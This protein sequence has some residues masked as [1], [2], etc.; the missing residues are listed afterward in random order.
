MFETYLQEKSLARTAV[1]LNQRGIRQKEWTTKGGKRRGGGKFRSTSLHFH[2]HNPLFIGKVRHYEDLYDGEHE[3]IV[4]ERLFERVQ[5][6]LAR[7][8]ECKKSVS[9]NKHNFLLRGLVR[10]ECCGSVMTTYYAVSKGKAHAYYRCTSVN[11]LNRGQCRVRHVRAREI[12]AFVVECLEELGRNEE[13]TGRV[14]RKAMVE[15][16]A[17]VPPLRAEQAR[18][19]GEMKKVTEEAD[20]LLQVVTQQGRDAAQNSFV[21]DH[22][23]ELD[24]RKR[25]LEAEQ[26]RI[27]AELSRL[28]ASAIDA[29]ELRVTLSVMKRV[30]DALIPQEQQEL[31]RLLLKEVVYDGIGRKVRLAVRHLPDMGTLLNENWRQLN[32]EGSNCRQCMTPLRGQ[33]SNLSFCRTR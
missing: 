19:A 16:A 2:L 23:N 31:M 5:H 11:N 24:G 9:Q 14:V 3:G 21:M 13:L 30:F 4:D 18:V 1:I 27:R 26:E 6:L 32:P 8:G 15:H 10:C 20:R 12:E 29:G 22:L 33:D 28:E 25:T 7:N 17:G